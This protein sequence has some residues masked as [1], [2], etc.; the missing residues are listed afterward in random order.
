MGLELKMLVWSIV[1]GL[2]YVAVAAVLST[3]QRGTNWNVGNREGEPK[4]LTGMS[5]RA[6]R[7]LR[8]FLE[9]FGFF[10]AAVLAVMVAGKSSGQ[11]GHGAQLYFWGRLVYL[12]V[13]LIGIPYL[14]TIVWGVATA[15][16]VL[17]LVGLT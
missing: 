13:Y 15:G 3:S 1:L 7:A 4:P 12:P 17:V 2:V 9:T 8:N 11:T 5:G 16:L 14:R 6:D 10:A